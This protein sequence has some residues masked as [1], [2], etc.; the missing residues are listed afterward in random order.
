MDVDVEDRDALVFQPQMGGGDRAVVEKAKAA[1]D[2]AKGVMTG[3]AAERVDGILAVHHHLRRGRCDIGGG[4]GG[5]KG[6]GPDRTAGVG[7]VPAQPADDMRRIRRGMAHRMHVGDHLGTGIAKRRPGVPGLGEKAEIFG[8]VNARPRA[9]PE[10]RRRDQL[11]LARFEPRQQPVGAL[12]LLGGALDHA[13]DEEELRIVAAMQFGVDGFHSNA[14][15]PESRSLALG[16]GR[17]VLGHLEV[18]KRYSHMFRQGSSCRADC[19]GGPRCGDGSCRA[20]TLSPSRPGGGEQQPCPDHLD[21]RRDRTG[22]GRLRQGRPGQGGRAKG[23]RCCPSPQYARRSFHQHARNHRRCAGLARSCHRICCAFR[24][25]CRQRRDL[26]SLRHPYRGH[27]A[28]HQYR[29]RDAGADRRSGAGTSGRCP[30]QE[31]Q[32]EGR[33]QDKGRHDREGDE[34]FRRL[35]PQPRRTARPQCGLGREGRPRGRQPLRQRGIA[36]ARHRSRRPRS[37]RPAE[38]SRWSH[39][40]DRR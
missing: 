26:H 27:G 38:A 18:Q 33:R 20:G 40:G 25:A 23:R 37:G 39:G 36:G 5:G 24:R 11:V 29:R 14:P 30:R 34:R 9:L 10:L 16:P 13:A 28:R 6:A 22:D 19:T 2:I 12:G 21:R 32:G 4:A 15:V 17:E 8:T 7:G 1:G 3:R 31:R 35:H